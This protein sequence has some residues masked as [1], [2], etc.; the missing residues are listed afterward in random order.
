MVGGGVET[1]GAKVKGSKGGGCLCRGKKSF[2][3]R[4]G[5]GAGGWGGRQGR[6]G[7]AGGLG[8]C[9]S[10][11]G[12]W[13]KRQN[14]EPW[15][16]WL[17]AGWSGWENCQVREGGQVLWMKDD[18]SHLSWGTELKWE[19]WQWTDANSWEITE[20]VSS[21]LV[22]QKE[23]GRDTSKPVNLCTI[24]DR[25]C[26]RAIVEAGG[27]KKLKCLV[28]SGS[29]AVSFFNHQLY[30]SW[31]HPHFVCVPGQDKGL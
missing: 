10:R 7:V 27:E 18:V 5:K 23:A 6:E 14:A 22:E 24:R 2:W 31:I 11:C 17:R 12:L 1:G 3:A 29:S 9:L 13:T 25:G 21:K 30:P 15:I 19:M 28:G 4:W 20:E 8:P 16:W 26:G